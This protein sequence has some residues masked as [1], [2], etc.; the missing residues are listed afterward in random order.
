MRYRIDCAVFQPKGCRQLPQAWFGGHSAGRLFVHPVPG[1]LSGGPGGDTHELAQLSMS[2]RRYDACLVV[3][4]QENLAWA[5]QTLVAAVA[6]ANIPFIALTD[7]LSAGAIGDLYRAGVRDFMLYPLCHDELRARIEHL[8]E[9]AAGVADPAPCVADTVGKYTSAPVIPSAEEFCEGILLRSG[10][11]LD[12]F[13]V[14]AASR[15]A[16]GKDS[17]R[18]MKC[19]IVSRFEQAFIRASLD[20]H[21]GNISHAARACQKHRRAFWGLMQKYNIDPTPFRRGHSQRGASDG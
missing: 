15:S 16:T 11:E 19:L 17:F 6:Q 8:L 21:S 5:R 18:K 1:N 13:A 3:V 9:P 12:A 2:L 7:N 4:N 14:A 10:G 20:C